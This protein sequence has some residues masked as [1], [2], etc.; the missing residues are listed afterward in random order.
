MQK[1]DT[2]HLQISTRH[3]PKV[4][5]R[6][7]KYVLRLLKLSKKVSFR[8]RLRVRKSS[9]LSCHFASFHPLL[10]S[11]LLLALPPNISA[12]P[13][14]FRLSIYLLPYFVPPS[15]LLLPSCLHTHSHTPSE[16]GFIKRL[17]PPQT[18][19]LPPRGR[20]WFSMEIHRHQPL[21]LHQSTRRVWLHGSIG[22][23]PTPSPPQST[24]V[25]LSEQLLLSYLRN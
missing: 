23:S 1:L 11:S 16:R 17:T 8:K 19:P 15:L 4:L 2:F 22:P 10:N 13:S 5:H 25:M 6:Q 14:V 21:N 24:S 12:S 20:A 3:E 9:V 7:R 18:V